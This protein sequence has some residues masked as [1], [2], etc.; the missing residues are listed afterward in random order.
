MNTEKNDDEF[1]NM[2]DVATVQL[3]SVKGSV[4]CEMSHEQKCP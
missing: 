4:S 1:G 3:D 2:N